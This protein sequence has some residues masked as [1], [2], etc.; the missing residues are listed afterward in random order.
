M[1]MFLPTKKEKEKRIVEIYSIDR[2]FAMT[3]IP[4]LGINTQRNKPPQISRD[5]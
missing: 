4:S 5:G 3:N 2:T 1:V